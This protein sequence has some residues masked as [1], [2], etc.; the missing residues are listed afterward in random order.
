MRYRIILLVCVLISFTSCKKKESIA[1]KDIIDEQEY[2]N[3]TTDTLDLITYTIAEDSTITDNPANAVLGSYVDP[4][5]GKLNA[6]FYTQFR[7]ATVNPDF[8]DISTIKIDSFILALEYAGYYGDLSAQTF[9]VFEM[10][11]SIYL[12]STYYAFTEKNT[13]S[14]NL[15]P[16]G[17]EIISP[18]PN[19]K[20]VV[21]ED[22]VD[23]QL[24]IPLDTNFAKYLITEAESG[25]TS[26]SSNENF[27]NFFKGLKVKTNNT[28]QSIG[29]GAIFY[30]NLNDPASKATIY[31]TQGGVSKSYDLLINSSCADFNHVNIQNTNYPIQ[32]VLSDSTKGMTEFYAQAFKHRAV[33]KIPGIDDLPEN[34]IVHRAE[35]T[36]PI[37][38]QTGY[39]FKPGAYLSVSTKI[40]SI[41]NNLTALPS[42]GEYSES[43]KQFKVDLKDYTQAVHNGDIENT[44][45]YLSPRFFINS[46]ERVVFN[47]KNS[48]NKKKPQLIITYSTF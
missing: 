47:G 21:G 42:L 45:V 26:F 37:Q 43:K 23:A 44:G 22:T 3:S 32:A 20:T 5:F 34:I 31:F 36:L 39:R 7:L 8:G 29:Q 30:F 11:E 28:N 48:T 13:K 41:D 2:L 9:Q 17:K 27:L 35:L 24:R 6:Y 4:K 10:D 33:V 1:G 15:I 18:R 38:F 25:S 19:D 46:A 12:D 14:T 40:K 16:A